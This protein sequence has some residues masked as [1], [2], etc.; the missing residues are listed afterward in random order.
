MRPNPF[1]GE[2][3]SRSYIDGQSGMTKSRPLGILSSSLQVS[4]ALYG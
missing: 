3:L 1:A 2:I 4:K